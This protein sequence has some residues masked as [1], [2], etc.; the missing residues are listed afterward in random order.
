MKVNSHRGWT[1]LFAQIAAA[2]ALIASVAT[3]HAEIRPD[4]Y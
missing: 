2:F 3:A 4:G 1:V